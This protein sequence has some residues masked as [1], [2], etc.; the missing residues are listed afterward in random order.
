MVKTLQLRLSWAKNSSVV[1]W[2]GM[3]LT[4]I[5]NKIIYNYGKM[6]LIKK[7]LRK[8]NN[9]EVIFDNYSCRF[10]KLNSIEKLVIYIRAFVKKYK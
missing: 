8:K 2:Y 1:P 4:T 6:S 10:P 3:T 7:T 5:H 9:W